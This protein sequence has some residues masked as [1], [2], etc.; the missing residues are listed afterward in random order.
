M[1]HFFYYVT[2]KIIFCDLIMQTLKLIK[3]LKVSRSFVETETMLLTQS[4]YSG[5]LQ[6]G[7]SYHQK[8]KVIVILTS[9]SRENFLINHILK[10]K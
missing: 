6:N 10:Q 7:I 3:I 2:Y 5:S 4:V 8:W 9:S 1:E